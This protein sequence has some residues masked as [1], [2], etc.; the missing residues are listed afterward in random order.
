MKTMRRWR[1]VAT[2]PGLTHGLEKLI[3][4]IDVRFDEGARLMYRAIDM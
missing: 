3:C 2:E 4:T 1:V